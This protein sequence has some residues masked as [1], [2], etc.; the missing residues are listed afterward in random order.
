MILIECKDLNIIWTFIISIFCQYFHFKSF[1]NINLTN[2]GWGSGN[3]TS[4]SKTTD[5][6]VDTLGNSWVNVWGASGNEHLSGGDSDEGKN[7]ELYK[8]GENERLEFWMFHVMNF[9]LYRKLTTN[10]IIL[11]KF[12]EFRQSRRNIFLIWIGLELQRWTDA[13]LIFIACIYTRRSVGSFSCD[14]LIFAVMQMSMPNNVTMQF[15]LFCHFIASSTR[16]VM[17]TVKMISYVS[18]LLAA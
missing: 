5:F 3:E 11:I 1:S 10:F 15:A 13:E 2:N 18:L 6:S 12:L 8:K 7:E 16:T 4:W 14:V 9:Y 17:F